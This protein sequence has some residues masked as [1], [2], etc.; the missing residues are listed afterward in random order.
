M[1]PDGLVDGATPAEARDARRASE[2][3]AFRELVAPWEAGGGARGSARA[4][5]LER[6][7]GD[8][9][10]APPAEGVLVAVDYTVEGAAATLKASARPLAV[11]LLLEP[12]GAA[13]APS[14]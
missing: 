7:S 12:M 10:V 11:T 3:H 2:A 1:P 6:S 8:A 13:A 9:L 14:C 5:L 4:E